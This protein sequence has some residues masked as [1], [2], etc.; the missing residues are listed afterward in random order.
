[1]IME[2]LA[3]NDIVQQYHRTVVLYKGEPVYVSA[4]GEDKPTKV[5]VL[6]LLSQH[7]KTV[8]FNLVDFTA[9]TFRIGNVNTMGSVYYVARR[10]VRKMQVGINQNNTQIQYLEEGRYLEGQMEGMRRIGK[11]DCIEV[12]NAIKGIYPSFE[13]C[14]DYVKQFRGTMA[15]DRQFSISCDRRVFYRTKSVGSLPRNCTRVERIQ[16]DKGYE[17]LDILLGD[18][19]DKALQASRSK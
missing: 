12:A 1:M 10:P 4:V 8:E 15:W 14:L 5:R 17:H 19:C 13:E 16:F 18:N 2:E 6:D 7:A 11:F 3:Y 9:P